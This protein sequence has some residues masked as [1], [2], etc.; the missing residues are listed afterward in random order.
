MSV[1][2]H[3]FMK[4]CPK[5]GLPMRTVKYFSQQP[6]WRCY[7]CEDEDIDAQDIE[8]DRW[9]R[10]VKERRRAM[11]DKPTPI[12]ESEMGGEG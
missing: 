10:R 2:V 4:P 7:H 8:I 12:D 1:P 5:H 11:L 9:L 6:R 3:V